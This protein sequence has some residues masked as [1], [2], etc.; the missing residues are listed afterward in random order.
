[1]I[2]RFWFWLP[3]GS[4][5]G[6]F[7]GAQMEAK[8][9]KKPLQKNTKTWCPK[10]PQTDPKGGPKMEPKSSKMRSW[11]SPLSTSAPKWSPEPLQHRFWSP[12]GSIWVPF[13]NVFWLENHSWDHSTEM[14]LKPHPRQNHSK[15]QRNNR[16]QGREQTQKNKGRHSPGNSRAKDTQNI[17]SEENAAKITGEKTIAQTH[18]PPPPH[19]HYGKPH[20]TQKHRKQ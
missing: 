11:I 17:E 19:T 16:A 20:L 12:F 7:L 9:I 5:F 14:K 6:G 15:P 4:H 8:A 18:A 1:M 10:W 13:L 2:F 3:F